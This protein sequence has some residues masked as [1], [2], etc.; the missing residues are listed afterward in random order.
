M[1]GA[2]FI[3]ESRR[4]SVAPLDVDTQQPKIKCRHKGT[5]GSPKQT[6]KGETFAIN[7]RFQVNGVES[8]FSWRRKRK[9]DE[10][11]K[12]RRGVFRFPDSGV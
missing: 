5:D 2:T 11:M 6:L 8:C 12:R 7:T 3:L 9:T 4:T 1:M 10:K